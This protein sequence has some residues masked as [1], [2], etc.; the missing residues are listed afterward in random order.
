MT[1]NIEKQ[2]AEG[3]ANCF[4]DPLGFVKYVY[5]WGKNGSILENET[6]DVWQENLLNLLGKEIRKK[7]KEKST[8]VIRFAVS[9]GHGVG[10]TALTSWLIQWF[11]STRINP[12]IIVTANTEIQLKTKTWRELKK[13]QELAING[14]WFE[15]KAEKYY[16]K[17]S[18]DTWFAT[19]IIWKKENPESVQGTHEKSVLII[20]DEASG[21]PKIIS[22]ALEGSLTT[23]DC[24]IF[25][26][27]NP[28]NASG[29]FYDCFHRNRN[30]WHRFSV[31]AR[32]AR[33]ANQ[34]TII[35]WGKAFGEDSDFFK[36]RVKGEFPSQSDMQFISTK[37][38]EDAIDRVANKETIKKFPL[39]MGVDVARFGS[40]KSIILFRQ[41]RKI[42][43]IFEYRGL[44]TMSLSDMVFE[45]NSLFSPDAIFID[46][47]GVGGGV[48]DRCKQLGLNPFDINFGSKSSKPEEFLNLRAE[49]WYK[50]KLWL[51]S[52][53][54]PN[55]LEIKDDLTKI[56]YYYNSKQQL[57]LESKEAMK[58]RGEASP[59]KADALALTFARAVAPK[60]INYKLEDFYT[61][62]TF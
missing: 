15:H 21:L 61:K 50:M 31:D 32:Q 34:D 47:G 27:G 17:E 46:G 8:K 18:P 23:D 60:A 10:K 40:D 4:D 29:D 44:D 25:K 5:S 42:L 45:K 59:D 41:G 24:Y 1:S 38:V 36:I 53:D 12:Q 52:G 35:D 26:F 51:D 37:T 55:D 11:M 43:D 22:E 49:M 28:N 7:N 62:N 6:I 30:L 48:V 33:K 19:P 57:F 14:H 13:W 54:I 9:S 16:L 58:K 2:L 56:E 3:V 39:I 20:I